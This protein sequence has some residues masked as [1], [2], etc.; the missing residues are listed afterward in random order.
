[1]ASHLWRIK[2]ELASSVFFW[3]SRHGKRSIGRPL[4]VYTDQLID[5]TGLRIEDIPAA[6]TDRMGWRELAQRIQEFSTWWWTEQSSAFVFIEFYFK[7]FT[8]YN[9]QSKLFNNKYVC[10][11]QNQWLCTKFKEVLS[12]ILLGLEIF[13]L[14]LTKKMWEYFLNSIEM[15]QKKD[16]KGQW[17]HNKKLKCWDLLT[18]RVVTY[19]PIYF[20]NL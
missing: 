8:S 7:Y 2:N 15:F 10:S 6:M 4:R 1:M 12:E 20:L 11:V 14:T 3:S 13:F 9:H 18:E 16:Q 19:D 5:D 17:R